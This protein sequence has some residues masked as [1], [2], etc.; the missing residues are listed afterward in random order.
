M[1]H[2]SDTSI[3]TCRHRILYHLRLEPPFSNDGK[4]LKPKVGLGLDKI[5]INLRKGMCMQTHICVCML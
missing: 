5:K 2:V 3:G 1:R 4:I